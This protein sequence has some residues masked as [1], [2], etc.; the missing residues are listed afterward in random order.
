M[1]PLLSRLI[2]PFASR[3][4]PSSVAPGDFLLDYIHSRA[5]SDNFVFVTSGSPTT[6]VG[7]SRRNVAMR[8]LVWC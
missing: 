3:R 4:P 5:A 6:L 1:P 2:R 8:G 7:Q